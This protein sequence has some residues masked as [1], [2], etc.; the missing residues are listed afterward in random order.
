MSLFCRI[1]ATT[2]A[3]H[4]NNPLS[5]RGYPSLLRPVRSV[6]AP[7]EY[8]FLSIEQGSA[9]PCRLDQAEKRQTNSCWTFWIC[10]GACQDGAY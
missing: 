6:V 1:L 2:L 10:K 4:A 3:S 8:Q 5:A 9:L 7:I